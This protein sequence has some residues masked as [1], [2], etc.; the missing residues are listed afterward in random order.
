MA[1][2]ETG[3]CLG[4]QSVLRGAAA[5]LGRAAQAKNGVE[6]NLAGPG[7]FRSLRFSGSH[8]GNQ[9][10]GRAERGGVG[11]FCMYHFHLIT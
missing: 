8:F 4:I 7:F 9:L 11:C 10:D 5:V 3:K 6:R 1:S 2:L